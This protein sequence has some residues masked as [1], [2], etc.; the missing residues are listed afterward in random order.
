MFFGTLRSR[1]R[2]CWSWFTTVGARKPRGGTHMAQLQAALRFRCVTWTRHG[3]SLLRTLRVVPARLAGHAQGRFI[4]FV[5]PGTV[6]V[7]TRARPMAGLAHYTSDEFPLLPAESAL[8]RPFFRALE[9]RQTQR[10]LCWKGPET[11][12]NTAGAILEGS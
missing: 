4:R 11:S 7:M 5:E 1:H 3:A 8:L 10:G 2:T 9:R 12:Q 6:R